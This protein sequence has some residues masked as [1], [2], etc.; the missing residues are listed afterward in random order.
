MVPTDLWKPGQV[1]RDPYRIP[2]AEDAHAPNR[3]R[4]EVGLYSPKVGETLGAIQVGEAKLAPAR[5]SPDVEHPL[6]VE[7]SSGVT[8][9]GYDFLPEEVSAGE[10]IT[11]TLYWEVRQPPSVDY[12]V[13][14][15]LLGE[16]PEPLAQGD[17]PPLLGDYPTSM[18][19]AGETIADPHPVQ[20]PEA[21]P[22]GHYR[23]TV[24]MYDLQTLRRLTRLDGKGDAV[25]IPEPVV[26]R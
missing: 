19:A 20:L 12:Q 13:F 16:G 9:L 7:L 8:L 5:Q 10:R 26:V 21:L 3:L 4:V 17:G 22:T 25:E 15:H 14:V 24:G 18:W 1:W 2:V 11:L 6:T 23:L